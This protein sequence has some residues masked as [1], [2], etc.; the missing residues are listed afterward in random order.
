MFQNFQASLSLQE[1]L[2]IMP[3]VDKSITIKINDLTKCLK[4]ISNSRRD[5]GRGIK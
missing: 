5:G 4:H 3:S 2:H 1:K